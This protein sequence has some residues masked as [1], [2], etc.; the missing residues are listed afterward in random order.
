MVSKWVQTLLATGRYLFHM[1][2]GVFDNPWD[3]NNLEVA[4]LRVNVGLHP[5]NQ[6]ALNERTYPLQPLIHSTL[7]AESAQKHTLAAHL[8]FHFLQPTRL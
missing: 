1:G 4:F 8:R 5:L 6:N 7:S 3:W 2:G